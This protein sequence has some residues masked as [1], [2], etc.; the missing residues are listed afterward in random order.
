L[1]R[2]FTFWRFNIQ[3]PLGPFEMKI[4]YSIN[5]GQELEFYVPGR[6]ENMRWAAHSVGDDHIIRQ[7][8]VSNSGFDSATG[9]VLE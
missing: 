3:V 4:K 1:C 7:E 6:F 9:S 2:T 8:F 5:E